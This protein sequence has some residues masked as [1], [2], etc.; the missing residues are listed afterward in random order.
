MLNTKTNTPTANNAII[1]EAEGTWTD[2]VT[3][4]P[5][6]FRASIDITLIQ[7]AKA[8]VIANVYAPNGDFFRNNAPASLLIQADLYK[9]GS[10]SSGSK[11]IKWFAADSSVSTSQDADGGVGWRK[12][13]ATTGTTKEVANSGFDVAVTTQGTLTVYPD[14]VTNAQTYK[15]IITDN[16]GGTSGQKTEN[17]ITIKDMDD[18]ILLTVDSSNG[19]VFKNGVGSTTLNARL[20]QNGEEIDIAGTKYTYKWSK[21]ENNTMN[22]TFGGTGNAY[23]TGKTLAI[24][25]SDVNGTSTFKCEVEG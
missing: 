21:W 12:I 18:P 15:V 14:A 1:W 17:Y 3:L 22:P 25:S 4:L 20:F 11:K 9:E 2:P 16:V 19:T 8:T 13:T 7:L 23:K 6:D 10:K 5:I 24:G